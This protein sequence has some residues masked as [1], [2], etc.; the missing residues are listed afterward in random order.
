M[1]SPLTSR[2]AGARRVAAQT[3]QHLWGA[4]LR[5]QIVALSPPGVSCPSLQALK[6]SDLG[7]GILGKDVTLDPLVCMQLT[8]DRAPLCITV[9][10]AA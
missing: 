10:S 5:V 4:V 8:C 6:L 9:F 3:G 1:R 2:T 7:S